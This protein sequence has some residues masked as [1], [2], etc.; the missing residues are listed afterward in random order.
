[1]GAARRVRKEALQSEA[2]VFFLSLFFFYSVF[3]HPF[4]IYGYF[5]FV[6]RRWR[7]RRDYGTEAAGGRGEMFRAWNKLLCPQFQELRVWSENKEGRNEE[8]TGQVR[9]GD[10]AWVPPTPSLW[11]LQWPFKSSWANQDE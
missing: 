7:K 10:L 8:G 3:P 5:V 11:P 4:L 6:F 1:M 9:T 2:M